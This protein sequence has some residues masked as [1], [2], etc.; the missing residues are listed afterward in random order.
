MGAFDVARP[1]D[2]GDEAFD[3]C[4]QAFARLQQRSVEH[5]GALRAAGAPLRSPE[6]LAADLV[7]L[8]ERHDLLD[9]NPQLDRA[10]LEA[11]VTPLLQRCD[12]LAALG[13][14]L[15]IAH[16]DFHQWNTT[17]HGDGWLVYDWTDSAVAP[18]FWDL[19]PWLWHIDD[20]TL[21]ARARDSYLREWDA[22]LG[23]DAVDEAWRVAEPLACANYAID[24]VVL[25]DGVGAAHQGD[26]IGAIGTW[27]RRSFDALA[28]Q[29]A[30]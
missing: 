23:R 24:F 15:T 21:R 30:R 13:L 7:A 12:D 4:L 25:A 8:L 29:A 5:T 1:D 14:P 11:D 18:P 28:Q 10:T 3:G 27:L 19:C 6:V 2:A 20:L 22:L 9:R 16:G 26:W 17:R